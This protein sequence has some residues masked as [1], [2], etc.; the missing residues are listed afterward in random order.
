MKNIYRKVV[1]N[2]PML[3]DYFPDYSNDY[4]PPWSFFWAIYWTVWGWEAH[5]MIDEAL[6]RKIGEMD[7]EGELIKIGA[8]FL[9]S[10]KEYHYRKCKSHNGSW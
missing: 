9:K 5:W 3:K 6:K 2:D 7:E 1:N 10:I 8:D 4:L